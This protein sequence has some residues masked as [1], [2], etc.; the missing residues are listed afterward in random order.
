MLYRI[1]KNI[2]LYEVH[3]QYYSACLYNTNTES[4]EAISSFPANTIF[5]IVKSNYIGETKVCL[6][7]TICNN[8]AT[9]DYMERMEI[10]EDGITSWVESELLVPLILLK[11][12]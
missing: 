11:K 5:K 2:V 6:L 4:E 3:S 8:Y 9:A 7:D 10:I 12:A 1:N